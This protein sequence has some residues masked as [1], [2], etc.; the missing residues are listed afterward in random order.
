MIAIPHIVVGAAIGAKT[1]NLGLIIIF[2]LLGHWIMDRIPHWDYASLK[3][4]VDFQQTKKIKYLL[5]FLRKLSVDILVGLL[6]VLGII[7]SKKNFDLNSLIF[8]VIGIF[9]SILPDIALT[10]ITLFVDSEKNKFAKGYLDF[11]KKFLHFKHKEKEGQITFLGLLTQI[12][13]IICALI[14]FFV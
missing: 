12:V 5:I 4:I 13:V 2:S 6:I 8:I 10:I 7:I 1:H 14:G 11:H 9:F 3:N